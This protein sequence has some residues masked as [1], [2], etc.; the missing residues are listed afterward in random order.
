MKETFSRRGLLSKDPD[1]NDTQKKKR[2]ENL[3]K[4]KGKERKAK[5][6][7]THTEKGEKKTGKGLES[8]KP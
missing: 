8:H 5:E 2:T 4:G 6:A 7:T 1:K 3:E